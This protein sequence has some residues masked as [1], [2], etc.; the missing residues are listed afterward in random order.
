M[1]FGNGLVE[2][3]N[4]DYT[5]N[6][7]DSDTDLTDYFTVTFADFSSFTTTF[8]HFTT[9]SWFNS[10]FFGVLITAFL[11]PYFTKTHFFYSIFF[12]KIF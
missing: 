11:N 4:F 12:A 8:T 1:L 10:W 6:H 2:F 3:N 7:F 9:A 5:T